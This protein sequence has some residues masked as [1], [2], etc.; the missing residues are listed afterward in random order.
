MCSAEPPIPVQRSLNGW[1][2]NHPRGQRE[3]LLADVL[4][5]GR[6][7]GNQ[8]RPGRLSAFETGLVENS[9][10]Q[11]GRRLQLKRSPRF[12]LPNPSPRK[13]TRLEASAVE[14]GLVPG[15]V[16]TF[17]ISRR[18]LTRPRRLH[19]CT[20]PNSPTELNT[21]LRMFSN[22]KPET[23]L[24]YRSDSAACSEQ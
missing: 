1:R 6:F 7:D 3:A 23:G 9:K 20:I 18:V 15:R 14:T 22:F 10:F 4:S 17:K 11:G 13:F 19:S 12:C 16:S 24:F 8:P 2:R 21:Q 5:N